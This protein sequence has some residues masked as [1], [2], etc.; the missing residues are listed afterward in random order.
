MSKTNQDFKKELLDEGVKYECSRCGINTWLGER[1]S[2]HLD[3]VDGNRFNNDRSNLR[4]L[5]PNCH[6]QTPT[7]CGRNSPRY[8][9]K[10]QKVS[11]DEFLSAMTS[12]QTVREVFDSLGLSRGTTNYRRLQ[13]LADLNGIEKFYSNEKKASLIREEDIDFGSYGWVERVSKRLQISPQ[14]VRS[15]M[16]R[17]CPDLLEK[18]FTRRF[19]FQGTSDRMT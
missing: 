2:L 10:N 8:S 16:T 3:H 6:S 1:L 9:S 14:K 12:C 15:W 4:F 13:R 17:N 7:Y 18:A 5:C 11:D 19:T